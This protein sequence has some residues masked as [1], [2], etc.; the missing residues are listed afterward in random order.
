MAII[1]SPTVLDIKTLGTHQEL[2]FCKRQ[3]GIVFYCVIFGAGT[4][5]RNTKKNKKGEKKKIHISLNGAAYRYIMEKALPYIHKY[6]GPESEDDGVRFYKD[7][8]PI[9]YTTENIKKKKEEIKEEVKRERE[10]K[11]KS[12]AVVNTTTTTT[13]TTTILNE[14]Y[15]DDEEDEDYIPSDGEDSEI[16]SL[17][18][19]AYD[20]EVP[21][22]ALTHDGKEIPLTLQIDNAPGHGINSTH[23][24]KY[25]H[26]FQMLLASYAASG[27]DIT[28]QPPNSPFTNSLDL[29][30]WTSLKSR[31]RIKLTSLSK[32]ESALTQLT[33]QQLLIDA[34]ES[35]FGEIQPRAIFNIYI[36]K[37]YSLYQTAQHG[38]QYSEFHMN[39]HI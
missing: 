39:V 30:F 5:L 27:I 15:D 26:D 11:R 10:T 25:S 33:A 6:Y 34:I 14:S 31:V 37:Q 1:T 36:Q 23:D 2:E 20:E 4:Y 7:G 35:S 19:N 3:N 21:I 22:V 24:I 16:E 17:D 13:T 8:I 28:L 32:N 12:K 9:E 38:E 29:G 18:S